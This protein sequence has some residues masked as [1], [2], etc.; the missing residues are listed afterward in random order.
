M[1]WYIDFCTAAGE[2]GMNRYISALVETGADNLGTSRQVAGGSSL[3]LA[4]H[5]SST[6]ERPKE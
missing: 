6:L 4:L 1:S 5:I 3:V 2:A